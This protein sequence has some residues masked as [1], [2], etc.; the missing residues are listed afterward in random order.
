MPVEAARVQRNHKLEPA[1]AGFES[2]GEEELAVSR[3]GDIG[4]ASG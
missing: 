2:A 4:E 3:G 1:R